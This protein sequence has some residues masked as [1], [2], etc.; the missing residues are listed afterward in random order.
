VVWHED[1]EEGSVS[2]VTARYDRYSNAPGMALVSD[3]PA[4]RSGQCGTASMRFT[5]GGDSSA[6]DL[7]KKLLQ[8]N[9]AGYNELYV[10][11][12]VKYQAGGKWHHTGVSFGGYNP[13]SDGPNP[14][15]GEKPNGDDRVSFAMEPVWNIGAPNPEVDFYNYWMN[16]HTCS[17]CGEAYWGNSLISKGTF[18]APDNTWTCL[19]VHAKLNTDM[20]SG[21]GAVLEVWNN[22]ALVQAFPEPTEPDS[23]GYWVH[24]S[25]CPVG[26][27]IFQCTKRS[28]TAPGPLNRQFRNSTALQLNWFWPQN[29][30]TDPTPTNVWFDDM[31]VA[32]Q[33]IGCGGRGHGPDA[34]P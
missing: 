14:R 32:T 27:D 33:R 11:W 29:Y 1:F 28:P 5:A 21:A 15:A 34:P 22:D 23:F 25:F 24:G 19:E 6:T 18:V 31:V 2:A 26:A 8:G 7:Y 20:S 10:R 17:S 16:M 13:P 9:G 4:R 12:Y 30:T 3:V